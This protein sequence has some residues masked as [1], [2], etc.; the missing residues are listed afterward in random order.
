MTDILKANG[1]ETDTDTISDSLTSEKLIFDIQSNIHYKAD[2]IDELL[3][4][5]NMVF[6]FIKHHVQNQ[7]FRLSVLDD[8]YKGRNTALFTANRRL[9]ENKSDHRIAHNFAKIITQFKVGYITGNPIKITAID[10]DVTDKITEFNDLNETDTLNTELMTDVSK[11]G[12]AYEIQY[13]NKDDEDISVLS[14]VFETFVIYDTALDRQALMGVRYV[15]VIKDA[16]DYYNVTL[17]T[18]KQVIQINEVDLT[19]SDFRNKFDSADTTD[20]FYGDVPVIE[21]ANNRFRMGDYEDMLSLFDAYD[22]ATSDTANHLTDTINSLLVIS[23]DFKVAGLKAGD[24]SDQIKKYNL[25][26]LQSGRDLSGKQTSVDAKYISPELNISDA[27]L[28]KERLRKDIFS[29]S[30]VPDMTDQNFTGN[31]SG[32]AMKYKLFGFEQAISATERVFKKSL[33]KR[34]KLLFSKL[35]T[36]KESKGLNELLKVTFIPNLPKAIAEELKMLT[37]SGTPVSTRTK[38]GLVSFIDDADA[39]LLSIE[40]EEKNTQPTPNQYPYNFTTEN[41]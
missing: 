26:G 8:Y 35:K 4:D 19:A 39:E 6:E 24:M 9:A 36:L 17:Y 37:D 11:Y 16:R 18:N 22:Q 27:D 13:R 25:L 33:I 30:N 15:K 41:E 34:Y 32:Q 23:G 2:G 28:Y 14:N 5:I 1:F 21:Y 12:R 38:L 20:H 29:L 7:I 3:G 31:S 40:E 10:K